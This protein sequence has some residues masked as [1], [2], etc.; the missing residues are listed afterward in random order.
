MRGRNNGDEKQI[1]INEVIGELIKA[2]TAELKKEKRG[3]AVHVLVTDLLKL[4]EAH[5]TTRQEEIREVIV[6][7]I[8]PTQDYPST[9]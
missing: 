5:K 6:R 4:L 7:W 8:D 9:D 2:V 3:S 1:E